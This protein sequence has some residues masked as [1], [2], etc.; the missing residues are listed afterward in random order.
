MKK[1]LII[2]DGNSVFIKDFINQYSVRECQIDLISSTYVNNILGVQN[3]YTYESEFSNKIFVHLNLNF[4]LFNIINKLNATYDAIIIHYVSFYLAPHIKNLQKLSNNLIA[5][6]WGSDFYRVSSKVKLKLQN[7]IYSTVDSIVFTSPK[8]REQFLHSKDKVNPEKCHVA[9]FGLPTLDEIDKIKDIDA[10]YKKE[11]YEKFNIPADKLIV[12]V[13]YNAN[14]S[15]NQILAIDKISELRAEVLDSIHL[16]FPLAYGNK[17]SK[18]VILTELSIKGINNFTILEDF[19][20][21]EDTAKLRIL[22]DILINIQPSDQFSGSMQETL[23][24][25][26]TV[27]AGDWLPYEEIIDNGANIYSIDTPDAIGD[28]ITSL[29]N[30]PDKLKPKQLKSIKDYISKRSSWC[31]NLAIWDSIIFK[32]DSNN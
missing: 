9:R 17:S 16:V 5:V 11:W 21:F 28:A 18:E 3:I 25:G 2:G 12:L 8:T 29:V 1:I 22:T 7:V 27:I 6:V 4:Q 24:A 31:N 32:E 14:L 23:Y 26:N 13:G 15:Q 19:Y 30:Y 10:E 20:N